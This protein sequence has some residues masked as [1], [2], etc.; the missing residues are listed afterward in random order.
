MADEITIQYLYQG[1]L[2][3]L[4]LAAGQRFADITK[5][6]GN[7]LFVEG[8]GPGHAEGTFIWGVEADYANALVRAARASG[9]LNVDLTD[10]QKISQNTM[11]LGSTTGLGKGVGLGHSAFHGGRRCLH[12]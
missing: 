1:R 12:S 3:S 7:N 8:P 9:E 4:P 6:T 10:V 5:T 2:G 11:A